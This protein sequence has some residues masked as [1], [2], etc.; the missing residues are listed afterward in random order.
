[1]KKK[2][3]LPK[4]SAKFVESCINNGET[5]PIDLNSLVKKQKKEEES[6]RESYYST[7]STYRKVFA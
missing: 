7:K 1:M 2:I 3:I 5:K 4:S 6:I